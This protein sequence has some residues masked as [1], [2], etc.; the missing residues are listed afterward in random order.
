MTN[1]KTT[2]STSASKLIARE[3]SELLM[4][5]LDDEI[6]SIEWKNARIEKTDEYRGWTW[7]INPEAS[8]WIQIKLNH[9]GYL[10]YRKTETVYGNESAK[11]DHQ[12]FRGYGIDTEEDK[13]AEINQAILQMILVMIER[14]DDIRV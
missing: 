8:V 14:Y 9:D 5:T 2:K 13:G 3:A 10:E 6:R 12:H 11:T 4:K 1:R 7:D